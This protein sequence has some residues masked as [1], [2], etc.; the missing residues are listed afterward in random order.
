MIVGM[1]RLELEIDVRTEERI[2]LGEGIVAFTSIRNVGDAPV[3]LSEPAGGFPLY[4]QFR[5]AETGEVVDTFDSRGCQT[6][7]DDEDASVVALLRGALTTLQPGEEITLEHLVE[8]AEYIPGMYRLFAQYHHHDLVF[9]STAC[10]LEVVL[11]NCTAYAVTPAPGHGWLLHA[12]THSDERGVRILLQDDRTL[13]RGSECHRRLPTWEFSQIDRMAF[14][15]T[16]SPEA[17]PV[18]LGVQ[19]DSV[20][21]VVPCGDAAGGARMSVATLPH[22]SLRLLPEGF[23]MSPEQCHFFLR[24]DLRAGYFHA[25]VAGGE[26]YL[27]ERDGP[28]KG[29]VTDVRISYRSATNMFSASWLERRENEDHLFS[30]ELGTWDSAGGGVHAD[31]HY[32][33][34]RCVAWAAAQNTADGGLAMRSLWKSQ[35]ESENLTYRRHWVGSD[36]TQIDEQRIPAL[37]GGDIRWAI[38]MTEGPSAPIV[39]LVD[40]KTVVWL[41]V[42]EPF[43]WEELA[44][45]SDCLSWHVTPDRAGRH[46]LSH[47]GPFT[48]LRRLL[49]CEDMVDGAELSPDPGC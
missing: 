11:P 9:Q 39:G 24:S 45:V 22:E 36:V 15:R 30:G 20:F 47:I 3:E 1:T 6:V 12:Y 4:Y 16:L 19:G 28:W 21:G 46:W 7:P 26:I 10:Q 40:N 38:D 8:S 37:D 13:P 48:G 42:A 29:H 23:Q 2:I 44:D 41:D 35:A 49:I 34:E 33:G 27:R 5:D 43:G 18:S 32:G 31:F 14:A 17:K 25:F